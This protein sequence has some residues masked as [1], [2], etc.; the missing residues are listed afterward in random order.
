MHILIIDKNGAATVRI[1]TSRPASGAA[2]NEPKAQVERRLRMQTMNASMWMEKFGMTVINAVMLAGL[3][4]ALI[5]SLIQ[6]F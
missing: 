5:A 1:R 6:S 3:P 4:L 2:D